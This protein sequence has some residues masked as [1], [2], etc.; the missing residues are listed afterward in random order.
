MNPRTPPCKGGCDAPAW[1]CDRSLGV[2]STA[3]TPLATGPTHWPV[4]VRAREGHAS[5]FPARCPIGVLCEPMFPSRDGYPQRQRCEDQ[6]GGHNATG[7]DGRVLGLHDHGDQG[8]Q[9]MTAMTGTI[10]TTVSTIR[11][12]SQGLGG[13]GGCRKATYAAMHI[14]ISTAA[15]G[16]ASSALSLSK[17]PAPEATIT[18]RAATR[19]AIRA[20]FMSGY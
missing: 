11:L 3:S 13:G 5:L 6:H 12:R 16:K 20:L 19:N 1:L 18:T 7:T 8:I 15:G 14:R 17:I 2:G 4:L 10:T 9:K